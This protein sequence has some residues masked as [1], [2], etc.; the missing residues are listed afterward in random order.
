MRRL[1]VFENLA[2][3]QVVYLSMTSPDL[4]NMH[5]TTEISTKNTMQTGNTKIQKDGKL[6]FQKKR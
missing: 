3:S 2:I 4:S 5:Y 6:V 1:I